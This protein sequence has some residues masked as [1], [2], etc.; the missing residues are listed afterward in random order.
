MRLSLS[1]AVA[2][3]C[4]LSFLRPQPL[5]A[6]EVTTDTPPP[7]VAWE[8]PHRGDLA[9]VLKAY[10]TVL[11]HSDMTKSCRAERAEVCMNGD[12]ED[13]RWL[14]S[15]PREPERIERFVR[16]IVEVA[17]S[18]PGDALGFA[19]AVY[20]VA[21]LR[22]PAE[23]VALAEDCTLVRWW[24]ELVLGMAQQRAG[25]YERAG[26]HFRTALP[27]AD[28]ALFC[29]LTGIGELLDD[30]DRQDYRRLS[31]SDRTDFQRR[32]WWLT[33]PMISMPGNDRWTEHITRRFELILHERLLWAIGSDHPDSHEAAVV[34]RG[35]EDSWTDME[36]E[37]LGMDRLG[38]ERMKRWTSV[39][40]ARYRFTPVSRIGDGVAALRYHIFADG[41]DEGYTPPSYGPVFELPAQFARFREGDRLFVAAAA[42]LDQVPLPFARTVFVLSE[43]PDS[44]PLVLGQAERNKRPVFDALLEP[45]TAVAGIESVARNKAVA[46][47]RIGLVPLPS[48]R[49]ALSDP[50]L[51]T[52]GGTDLPASRDEAVASMLG[53]TTIRSGDEMAVYWEV[54]GVAEN[55]PLT[56]SLSID[57]GPEGWFTRV[58]SALGVR[59]DARGPVVSWTESASAPTHLM[60]LSLDIGGLDDGTYHLRITVAGADGSEAVTARRFQVDR[61]R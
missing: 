4:G 49:F 1:H 47:A 20:A 9:N 25:R 2:A 11:I 16:R 38:T 17:R 30:S 8:E 58:L 6:Q 43:G 45:P 50:I 19:Q 60:A 23:A 32:F 36:L 7:E 22:P 56:I 59:S 3:L 13:Q 53:R 28:P 27:E 24:C 26:R 5:C 52:P 35:H 31:C 54:Y 34:R 42:E 33:D 44:I 39:G 55:Q 51:V 40:A 48:E 21:R 41:N 29:R 15:T 61:S 57:G 18:S 14:S 12:H 46:R 37:R 10:Y